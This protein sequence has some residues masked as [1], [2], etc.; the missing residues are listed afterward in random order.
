MYV[1]AVSGLGLRQAVGEY[2]KYKVTGAPATGTLCTL[3]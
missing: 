3:V 1:C 2:A